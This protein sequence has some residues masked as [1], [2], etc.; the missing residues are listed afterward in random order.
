MQHSCSSSGLFL[1]MC[2]L[3]L[4]ILHQ[5]NHLC[6][7]D[8]LFPANASF[9]HLYHVWDCSNIL[10]AE[11]HHLSLTTP[12][13]FSTQHG[14]TMIEKICW[15]RQERRRGVFSS[16][17]CYLPLQIFDNKHAHSTGLSSFLYFW[18]LEFLGPSCFTPRTQ[19]SSLECHPVKPQDWASAL[20]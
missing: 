4:S 17:L 20:I 16:L 15:K 8:P 18:K 13:Q 3:P 19:I 5:V 12:S 1:H 10:T 2:L 6:P 7:P 9:L 14:R 11:F